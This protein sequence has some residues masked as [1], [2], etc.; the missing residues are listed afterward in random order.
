MKHSYPLTSLAL[1]LGLA[2][3][4]SSSFAVPPSETAPPAATT[5]ASPATPAT[6]E[7]LTGG[8]RLGRFFRGTARVVG[9]GLKKTGQALGKGI[10]KMI[11]KGSP[12]PKP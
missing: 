2:L 4:A 1:A 10:D 6:T 9:S 11:E 12:K 3:T 8:Q 5:T 7:T